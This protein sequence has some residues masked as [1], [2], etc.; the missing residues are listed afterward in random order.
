MAGGKLAP[1]EIRASQALVATGERLLI[2]RDSDAREIA[3]GRRMVKLALP[4]GHSCIR[5]VTENNFLNT[6]R[7]FPR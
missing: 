3:A 6:D 1:E 4:I 2:C 5:R 7:R